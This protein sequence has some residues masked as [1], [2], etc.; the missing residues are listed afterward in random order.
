MQTSTMI[1]VYHL[2]YTLLCATNSHALDR[3][4]AAVYEHVVILP[5][6][7]QHPVTLQEALDLMNRNMDVL[8]RAIK[9]AAQQGAHLIVTPEDGIYGWNFSRQT[10]YPYLE[11]IPDPEVNWIPCSEPERFGPAPVQERLSCLAKNNSIYVVANIG[12]KKAC[13]VSEAGCPQDGHYNY[14]TAVVFDSDGKL[15]AR[16]HKYNLFLGEDQFNAPDVPEVVTF[17]T[18]FGKFGIFICFDILFYNPAVALVVAHNVDTIIFPTA[19][20]NLLPHLTAIEFHS[21]W[22]MGMGVNLLSANTHNTSRKMTGSG[23]FSPDKVVPYYY[24]MDTEEGHLLISDLSA[25]PRNSSTYLPTE[26]DI[27][28]SSIEN[29][30]AGTNIFNG[31]LF[32]DEFT[33]TELQEPQGNYT[34]CQNDL[35]CHLSY[36]MVEKQSNEL[37]VL[38]A[39]DGLHVDEGKYYLQV[40]TLLKCEST[41]LKTCGESVEMASTRFHSFCLSGTFATSYVFPEVLLS[42]IHLAPG[43]FKV[44]N[45]GRLISQSN[46]SSRP[47]LS[48]TLF[49]RCYERDP[50]GP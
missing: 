37:Y 33:F 36:N 19:W 9:T 46:I 13:N 34:I 5:D 18:P 48:V 16:Y 43:M 42:Q 40:C 14:N 8:E 25:H 23:I 27:Y 39:F 41:D 6:T 30:P 1:T 29:F 32:S 2:I 38:G 4:I 22:A 11:D 45:D 28:A 24:N 35:C 49:G 21:A 12:D 44:L 17:D 10:I 20:M 31:K 47:L 26:W 15:T 7:T 50:A 3:Y